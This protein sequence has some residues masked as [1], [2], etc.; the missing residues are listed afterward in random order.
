MMEK[1]ASW[2][3]LFGWITNRYQEITKTERNVP[4]SEENTIER[5]KKK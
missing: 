3:Q 4:K 2:T 5:H 1:S